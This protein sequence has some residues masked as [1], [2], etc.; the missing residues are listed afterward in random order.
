MRHVP[1]LQDRRSSLKPT[2]GPWA[3]WRRTGTSTG[4]GGVRS[5]LSKM[6]DLP[7]LSAHTRPATAPAAAAGRVGSFP[8]HSGYGREPHRNGVLKQLPEAP[9][10]YFFK[11]QCFKDLE[12]RH[13]PV[14]AMLIFTKCRVFSGVL[15]EEWGRKRK[16]S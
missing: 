15:G 4:P 11:A 14:A 10:Y 6:Q 9:L 8:L 12:E 5:A 7:L 1:S 13:K 2:T 3:L 16:F